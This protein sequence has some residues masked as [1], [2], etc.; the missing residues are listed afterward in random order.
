LKKKTIK[1]LIKEF[2]NIELTDI[3]VLEEY[4]KIYRATGV[5]PTKRKPSP[6]A[7]LQRIKKGQDL[8][9]VNNLVDVY[10]L[11]VMKTQ[12]SMGAFDM[13]NLKYP[14]YLRFAKDGEEFLPLMADKSSKLSEGE[15]VYADKNDLIFCRDLNY[16][17][18]DHTKITDNTKDTILYV[19]G[20]SSISEKKLKEATELAV[21][22]ILKYCG[23]K[24]EKIAYTF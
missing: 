22:W 9:N 6:F 16:R 21:K 3:P 24:V 18:S 14:T 10:N 2:K 7:L 23:G 17:D 13:K 15:L 19:D 1:E 8:Y 11:A 12:V 5:D 4:R 20:T